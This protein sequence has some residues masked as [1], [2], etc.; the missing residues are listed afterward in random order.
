MTNVG[1]ALRDTARSDEVKALGEPGFAA[2]ATVDL[3]IGWFAMLL[4]LGKRPPEADQRGAL[5]E[6]AHHS[7]RPRGAARAGRRV[8]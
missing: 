5:Q 3:L 1:G 6:V 8:G 7:G 4:A 2:R